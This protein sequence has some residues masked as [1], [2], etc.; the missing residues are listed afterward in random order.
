MTK[1]E[2]QQKVAKLLEDKKGKVVANT[3]LSAAL[4]LL[5][6][7]GDAIEKLLF[8]VDDQMANEKQKIQQDLILDFIIELSETLEN[9][10]KKFNAQSTSTSMVIVDGAIE[11]I[12][13]GSDDVTGVHVTTPTEFKSGTRIN[14]QSEGSKNVTGLKIGN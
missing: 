11:V 7:P 5:T 13:K 10:E 4:K 2:T 3:F 8:G 9:F 6:S 14:V 1:E 12:D